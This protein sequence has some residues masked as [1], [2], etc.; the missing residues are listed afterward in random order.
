MR[1][2]N[3]VPLLHQ[4]SGCCIHKS[5]IEID[6]RRYGL[7]QPGGNLPQGPL[8]V[9]VHLASVWVPFTSEGKEAIADYDEIRK[10][11]KLAVQ[12]CARKLQAY[13]NRRKARQYQTDRRSIFERYIGEVVGACAAIKRINRQELTSNLRTIAKRA[14]ARADEE[15]G[16]DGKPADGTDASR[17]GA[18]TAREGREHR[19]GGIR[20][21]TVRERSAHDAALPAGISTGE[22][23]ENTI[24]VDRAANPDGTLFGSAANNHDSAS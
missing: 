14:T 23:G 17:V 1:F 2:A 21:G 8:A 15:I 16:L 13:L 22:Y 24:V 11:I 5:V 19:R 7:P 10:E 3:R 20:A 18:A 4:L 6:W 12:D 9:L